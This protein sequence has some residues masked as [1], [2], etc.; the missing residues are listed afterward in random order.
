MLTRRM[1]HTR[2]AAALAAT[3]LPALS[4]AEVAGAGVGL[5]LNRLTFGAT[6]TEVD[7]AGKM[8]LEG[9][10]DWQVSLPATDPGLEARLAATRLRISY[11]AGRDQDG[12]RWPALDEL[13]PLALTAD[14]A[15]LVRLL[16]WGPGKGMHYNERI[17]PAQEVAAAS[18]IRA[19]HAPAQLREVMT[20]FWHDHFSVNST[21]DQ[22]TAAFFASHDAL[23]RTHALGN[24][25][26]L[27]GEVAR[28]PAMLYYL[29]NADSIASPA[30]EN[31]ARELLELHT[32]GAA[33]YL[34]G[35]YSDWREVPG[36][37]EGRAAGYLDLDVYE[38]ARA[39][40]GWSVGDG[41]QLGE[42]ERVPRTGRFHYVARWHDPYQKRVLGREFPPNRAP[43]ADGEDVLDILASH[44][45]TARFICEKIA[46][47]LL[48]DDPPPDLVARL[49]AEFLA[50]S[51]APDQIAR[52]L[53]LL[54]LS[55]D[56]AGPP[57][58]IRRP[59]EFLAA[60]YRATGAEVAAP[61]IAWHWEL[62]RAG[63]RQHQYGPPTGHPDRLPAWTGSSTLIRMTDLALYAH[64]DWFGGGSV[65]LAALPD[66]GE[67]ALRF[68]AR[69]AAALCPRVAEGVAAELAAA[70]G[71]DPDARARDISPEAR[72]SSAAAAIAFAAMTPDFLLR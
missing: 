65:D 61:D 48:S 8:G 41:R 43:M 70:W 52:V 50:A 5:W 1:F 20:Q 37:A 45:A 44:P 18:L 54:V 67:T 21:K 6:R 26:L 68:L 27:L 16:D 2:L 28:S 47:R 62:S 4:H 11:N 39:F 64:D 59:F 3:S 69:H 33:S 19:V 9:W 23:L 29:N 15:D 12:N 38:V 55:A 60:L 53:R 40:T 57:G 58:K 63:W 35:H 36:A 13:R 25:R 24:F 22:Y 7:R 71:F 46:R 49:A 56:F 10:L 31:Y 32:L 14:P 42:G 34:N 17:R 72:R 51:D 30:N 66:D